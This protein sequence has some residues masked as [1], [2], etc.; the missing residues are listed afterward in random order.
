MRVLPSCLRCPPTRTGAA[1]LLALLATAFSPDARAQGATPLERYQPAPVGDALFA[2]PSASQGRYFA[3]DAG[4]VFSYAST[5][6]ALRLRSGATGE[7]TDAGSIVSHQA[8]LHAMASAVVL[9]RLKLDLDVPMTVDQSGDSPTAAGVTIAS[10]GGFAM[11]DLRLGAR[12][13]LLEEDGY[14]PAAALAFSAFLPTGDSTAFTGT[15]SA[16]FEPRLILGADYGRVVWSASVAR[17]LASDAG[18]IGSEVNFA[19]GIAARID[20]FQI[21]PE[22]FGSAVVDRPASTGPVTLSERAGGNLEAL[23]GA[24]AH[25]GPADLGAAFG[26]GFLRG[27]GTPEYRIILGVSLHPFEVKSPPPES[28]PDVD[29]A[30][31]PPPGQPPTPNTPVNNGANPAKLPVPAP[32][33]ADT[34]GDGVPDTDD[35]CPKVV[36]DPR[37]D[38]KSA[39]A[40]RSRR[41]RHL[42]R[43]GPLPRS[44]R[45]LRRGRRE[46]LSPRHRRRR[47]PRP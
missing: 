4:L 16:R 9:S 45:R 20:R 15:G 22:L 18:F 28:S 47:P 3:I 26:L 23:L 8:V 35:A 13:T 6:L 14:L 7:Y 2:S 10:P 5:P 42:R 43:R 27:A 24:K 36:G 39:A 37:P 44:A 1:A 33:P 17:Q 30:G 12:V 38:A 25:I 46:R 11:N 29:A 32:A 41:R 34:D 40:P 31:S 21:G 19:A